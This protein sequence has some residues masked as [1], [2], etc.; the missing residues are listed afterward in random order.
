MR[1]CTLLDCRFHMKGIKCVVGI[2]KILVIR[3][4][5]KLN[6]SGKICLVRNRLERNDVLRSTSKGRANSKRE[7]V[8]KSV[9]QA[10]Q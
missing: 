2:D 8:L 4:T 3:K 1:L 5:M 10:P 6:T 9:R 7:T